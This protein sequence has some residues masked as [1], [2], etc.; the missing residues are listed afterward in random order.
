MSILGFRPVKINLRETKSDNLN[1]NKLAV[2]ASIGTTPLHLQASTG[3]RTA[4][5]NGNSQIYPLEDPE[6][7]WTLQRFLVILFHADFR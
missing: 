2:A 1:M 7:L 3:P 6:K 5:Q 4:T